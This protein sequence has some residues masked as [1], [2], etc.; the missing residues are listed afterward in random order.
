M[1]DAKRLNH[2]SGA[3]LWMLVIVRVLIGWH[4]L[5][6]GLVKIMNPTWSSLGY[7]MD[8]KGIFAGL[9]HSI[10]TNPGMVNVADFLN[11]WGLTAIGL[12]LILGC[13]TQIATVG[14]IVLLAFY[15]LAHPSGINTVYVLPSEG[16]Y[17]W[18]NK[19]LI[20]LATLALLFYFP[21]GREIG[22]DRIL[23]GK[24][25]SIENN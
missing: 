8:S 18:V 11:M 3:Q 19:T 14:G 5:Y 24:P 20:E 17:L 22:F 4:F 15:C 9:F 6:E 7:L 23:F 10:A 1:D 21:T 12:G 13:F 16:S 25:K 2:F